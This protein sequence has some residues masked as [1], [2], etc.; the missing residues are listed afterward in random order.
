MEIFQ[1]FLDIG[2]CKTFALVKNSDEWNSICRD[3]PILN[4]FGNEMDQKR[5][6]SPESIK[7]FLQ[8]KNAAYNLGKRE[9]NGL[10]CNVWFVKFKLSEVNS[11]LKEHNDREI[12]LEFYWSANNT[13]D[14]GRGWGKTSFPVLTVA[15]VKK[16]MIGKQQ[17]PYTVYSAYN[18]VAHQPGPDRFY[19]MPPRIYCQTSQNLVNFPQWSSYYSFQAEVA[20]PPNF[21]LIQSNTQKGYI[22]YTY[23]YFD[24]VRALS[25]S[26]YQNPN[27]QK[28]DNGDSVY[29]IHDHKFRISYKWKVGKTCTAEPMSNDSDFNSPVLIDAWFLAKIPLNDPLQ[30]FDTQ[31]R[32]S[33]IGQRDCRGAICDVFATSRTDW[34]PGINNQTE[35]NVT[36]VWEWYLATKNWK[37][38]TILDT[39][40]QI[41]MKLDLTLFIIV[42]DIQYSSVLNQGFSYNFF[43]YHSQEQ[44]ISSAINLGLCLQSHGVNS[45]AYQFTMEKS[46]SG[47]FQTTFATNDTWLENTIHD[48]LYKAGGMMTRLR[49]SILSMET[50]GP[51]F[52][53]TLWN[54]WKKQLN[55]PIPF[56][57]TEN[58]LT[59]WRNAIKERTLKIP[60]LNRPQ[61]CIVNG[62]SIHTSITP[63]PAKVQQNHGYSSGAVAGIAIGMLLVGIV[64]G[65]IA[66][67]FAT[68]LKSNGPFEFAMFSNPNY[69]T[70][71][72]RT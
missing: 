50:G 14:A 55:V 39:E 60:L 32:Y 69:R 68:K 8:S 66:L 70:E 1:E 40:P 26:V 20:I 54:P 61:Q 46:C 16:T 65:V 23:E 33:I 3:I 7:Q 52:V 42:S 5:I 13:F 35:T 11:Y 19:Q 12:D 58:I 45:Q 49:F 17:N 71:T 2:S 9:V 4:L 18:F 59:N 31:R 24:T 22:M 6:A 15:N 34:P 72:P 28:G 51:S 44:K 38:D 21:T 25:M 30:F 36:S 64:A 37:A 62:M 53:V 57:S 27:L 63:T 67:F 43:N 10:Q 41:P 56:Q 29:E 47:A 48:Q